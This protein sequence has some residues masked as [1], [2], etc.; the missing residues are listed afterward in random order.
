MS[1]LKVNAIRQTTATSDAVTL[2][3]DG[4]CTVK[5]T[6]NLSNK[7]IAYNGEMRI[8]Q[9]STSEAG[10]GATS[11]Y[12]A[13]DRFKYEFNNTAG[14]V[15][16]SQETDAP[17]G[18]SN[19]LKVAT[20]TADTTIAADELFVIGQR[21]EGQDLQAFA[22]GTSSAK[23]FSVSF[24]VKGNAAATYVCELYDIDNNRHVG[25]TFSVTTAWSR[26]TLL[27]PADTTGAFGV[28]INNS[29][30]L[31]FWLHGG[32]NFTGGTLQQTWGSESA[33][34]RAAGISSVFDSTSRTF[35]LTGVQLEVGDV[36]T[37]FE[38]RSYDEELQRCYRYYEQ[39]NS[40]GLTEAMF[41]SGYFEA[42]ARGRH[43]LRFNRKRATP[44]ITASA[45]STF[46]N[47]NTNA[48]PAGNTITIKKPTETSAE[49]Q[50]EAGSG[51][52]DGTDGQGCC[53]ASKDSTEATIKISAEL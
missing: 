14:R 46:M 29:L 52:G 48:V 43:C 33:S 37:D 31:N 4:T 18:F 38:H 42:N 34:S 16:V 25:K 53:L 5:A 7:N 49:F 3:S 24:Y 8:S 6:N 10:L 39:F 27:F 12:S 51:A 11:K 9:R 21:F 13:I 41:A 1:T 20:T 22:K 26:V 23:Q 19:S 28:D 47:L 15:T 44:T 2:A 17:D 40:N 30:R 50:L 36:A 45:A 32:S 35:F